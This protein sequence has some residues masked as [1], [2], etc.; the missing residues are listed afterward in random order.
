MTPASEDSSDRAAPT[1]FDPC[2]STVQVHRFI[3]IDVGAESIKAVELVRAG[4]GYRWTRR[5][6]VEHQKDVGTSLGTLLAEW[7][8]HGVSG[9]AATGRLGRQLDLP[10]I[11]VKQA[12]IGGARH[13]LGDGPMT[14]VSIG[15][16]GFSILELRENGLE[17]FRENSRCS[18]GTGNF[19]RQLIG[20]FS[21]TIEQ[22]DALCATVRTP[23]V[24]SGR[25][26]VILKTDMTHLANKG[27]DRAAILAG[28]FDAVC[29][30]VLVL[31]KPGV[32]PGRVI[33]IGGVARSGRVQ[34]TF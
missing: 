1:D 31:I 33:L 17:I 32:C 3:G 10:Q 4:G 12:Q 34:A 29:E 7:G 28:L 8:W 23:A 6:C 18:Q 26:P 22:A 11:P 27:E 19:L 14:V 2:A 30:N 20:R 13:L 16:H 25:C 5:R 9:A 24:L 21:L 15:S